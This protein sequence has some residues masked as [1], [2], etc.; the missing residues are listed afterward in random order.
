MNL[1]LTGG[2]VLLAYLFS[3]PLIGVFITSAPVVDI[4]Q[5]LLHIMLWSLIIYG[6]AAVLSGLMRA[7]GTVLVPIGVTMFCIIAVQVPVAW[8]LSHLIGL[9]GVWIGY[10]AAFLTMLALQTSYYR[11]VWRKKPIRRL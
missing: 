2:L 6:M 9:D 1:V 7:S 8:T 11:L 10:P 5:T 4:T 3:R